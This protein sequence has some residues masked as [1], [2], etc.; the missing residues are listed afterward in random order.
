MKKAY[1]YCTVVPKFRET[2]YYYYLEYSEKVKKGSYV[3][4]PFGN[5]EIIGK[6][7]KVENFEE[8]NVPFPIDKMKAIRC[9]ISKEEFDEYTYGEYVGAD[10]SERYELFELDTVIIKNIHEAGTVLHKF[11]AED[12]QEYLY[13]VEPNYGD[14]TD[15]EFKCYSCYELEKYEV[16]GRVKYIGKDIYCDLINNNIYDIIGVQEINGYLNVRVIDG[17]GGPYMYSWENPS[18]LMNPELCG[19]WEI[20]EDVDGKLSYAL[21]NP[22]C[23]LKTVM[24]DD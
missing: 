1:K 12:A 3:I 4:A 14:D 16:L 13:K 18:N 2:D 20:F 5:D 8:E 23:V 17:S 11:W 9:V 22:N 10:E 19:K 6:V 21:E 24:G 15:W 7:T